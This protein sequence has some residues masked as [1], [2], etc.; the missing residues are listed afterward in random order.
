MYKFLKLSKAKDNK[1]KYIA[2]FLNLDTNREINVPF[3]AY[4]MS[5]YTLHKNEERKKLYIN[6]HQKNED[7]NNP[8][9]AGALSRFIL[10]NKLTIKDSLEDYL[11][12]F[13]KVIE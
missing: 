5:D 6:R 3:G 13:K 11:K 2:S 9:S 7:W 1:H 8:V 4:G 10:W 12:R